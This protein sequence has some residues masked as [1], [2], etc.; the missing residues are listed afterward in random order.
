VKVL[1]M[2]AGE[3]TQPRSLST[4]RM[5]VPMPSSPGTG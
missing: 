3:S 4:E 1:L 5:S 2:K